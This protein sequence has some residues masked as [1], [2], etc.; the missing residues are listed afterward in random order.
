MDLSRSLHPR[1]YAATDA[2]EQQLYS[3]G[4]KSEAMNQAIARHQGIWLKTYGTKMLLRGLVV[5]LASS[6]V[7]GG[8]ALA[9]LSPETAQ[10]VL[11]GAGTFGGLAEILRFMYRNRRSVTPEELRNLL[12]TLSLSPLEKVY[13]EA[14]I[15]LAENSHISDLNKQEIA[16]H[17]NGLLDAHIALEEQRITAMQAMGDIEQSAALEAERDR[18]QARLDA[19]VDE[20][21][22]SVLQKSL[23]LCQER[24]NNRRAIEPSLARLD[25]QSE[26]IHQGMHS[27]RESLARLKVVPTSLASSSPAT[28]VAD[29]D[30]IKRNID[31]I[32]SQTR[33]VEKAV[34]EV[35]QIR[36]S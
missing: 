8:I 3:T 21:T 24:L 20:D 28:D 18:I 12:P 34:Q 31:G 36:S 26:L 35:L 4:A 7:F 29:M 15:G 6:A 10:T 19:A 17:L 11:V 14:M 5:G 2:W 23:E 32:T 30:T 25:A 33:S 27:L 1:V 9:T 22:R 16:T 13:S